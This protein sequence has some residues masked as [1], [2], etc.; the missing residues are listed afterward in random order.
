V[1]AGLRF[2][3]A[4]HLDNSLVIEPP[5]AQ[6][7]PSAATYF[8]NMISTWA[9]SAEPTCPATGDQLS[10]RCIIFD[11]LYFLNKLELKQS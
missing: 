1:L 2:P 10:Q 11:S 7:G 9:S 8:D 6:Y 5:A 3:R 4:L